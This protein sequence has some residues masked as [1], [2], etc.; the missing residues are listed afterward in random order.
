MGELEVDRTLLLWFWAFGLAAIEIEIEGGYGWAERLPTWYRKRGRVGRVYGAVMGNRPLTGY[1]VFA[2]TIPLLILHLPFAMGVEWTLAAELATIATYFVLAVV[3]DYLW[4]V[5]N[6]AYTMR[7][8]ERGRV[9]WFEV[10]WIWRFPLDYYAGVLLSIVLATLAAWVDRDSDP[11]LRHLWLLAGLALL[12]AIAVLAAPLYQRW[13]RH[14]RRVGADDRE[15]TR[16]Y[17]PPEPD[18]AWEGGAPDL[19]PLGET[20]DETRRR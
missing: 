2:F 14:M 12:T 7:R 20:T 6:P 18:A 15:L 19:A 11:L 9:W 13:Y 3:W 10:P 1:H 5:L 16:T 8:F 4:F 17:P